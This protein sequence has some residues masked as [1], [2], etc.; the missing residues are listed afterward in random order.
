[1]KTF[2]QRF[3]RED[4]GVTAIEYGLIAGLVAAVIVTAITGVT[5]GLTH[6]FTV[7]TTALNNI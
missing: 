2:T 5:G 6:A 4:K 1:M 7:I 3:L